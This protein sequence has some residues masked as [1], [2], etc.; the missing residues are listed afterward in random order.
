MIIGCGNITHKALLECVE[1]VAGQLGN[2]TIF[3][4]IAF[5]VPL[6][7]KAKGNLGDI[8]F[9]DKAVSDLVKGC[10]LTPDS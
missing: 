1:S 5:V 3:L 7:P 10:L 9:S 4:V 6:L 8:K 2:S